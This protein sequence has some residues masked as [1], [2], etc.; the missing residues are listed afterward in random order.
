MEHLSLEIFDL[1]G[2][3]SKYAVLPEDTSITITD[4]SEI[5]ASGD[6]WSY[7]FTL[8]T[9]AN[10][11]IFGTAGEMHGA[12]LH[13]QVNRR[14]ARLWVEGLP[15]YYG[16]LR[17][18]DEVDVDKDG[19]V[20]VSF[21][22]GQKTFEDMIDGAKANQVP[23]IGNVRIGVALWRKRVVRCML[24]LK[25]AA[26]F[27]N[28]TRTVDA[29][30]TGLN[31]RVIEFDSD[32]EKSPAQ[33]YPRMVFPTG[34][35]KIFTG[36]TDEDADT[37][38]PDCINTDEPYTEDDDGTP[39]HPYCNVALCYQRYGY[40]RK[41]EDGS[42]RPDYST[43][44]EAQRGYEYMP[45]DRVNS[46]PNFFVIYWIRALMR[47]LGIDIE[48]NQMMD[49][50]DLRRLFFVN[51]DCAYKEPT[52]KFDYSNDMRWYRFGDGGRLVPERFDQKKNINKDESAFVGKIKNIGEPQYNHE[53]TLTEPIPTI[54][55]VV[56]GID[57]IDTSGETITKQVYENNNCYLHDAYA[58]SDC[59]P[60]ADIADVIKALESG[61]GVRFLFNDNYQRVR[62]VL[63]RNIFRS[64]EVQEIACD[65]ISDTK[66]ENS[67]RGFRMTYGNTEDTH[68]YYKG[69]ADLLPHKKPYFIDDSDD[70][71]YSHWNL[72]AEYANL[73]HRVSAFDKTCYVTP[74]TGNAYGI[75]V[76]KDA[77]RYDE[78]HP[79]LFEFAGF[80]DAEDGDC[81]GEENTIETVDVGFTPAIMND[82]NF[83]KE[84]SGEE[85]GQRF[86]L[87]VDEK[88]QPRRPD[89][90]TEEDYND[91]D[92]F[93]DVD[94]ILY[95]KK[96]GKNYDYQKMM[97][98]GIV[99][100]GEFAIMSDIYAEKEDLFANLV[101]EV[102]G[103]GGGNGEPGM[104]K[105]T[106]PVTFDVEGHI[107]EGY[108]LYLQDNY[109]PNDDGVSPVETHDWGLTLGI[110]RGSGDDAYVDYD[111]DPDD[112]EGNDTWDIVPGSTV[113]AH[114]DTCDCYGNEWDYNGSVHVMPGDATAKLFEMFPDSDA[115]FF[116][117]D[118]YITETMTFYVY[119][120]SGKRHLVLIAS[121]YD[122][123][124]T[125]VTGGAGDL[126]YFVQL[127]L[128]ELLAVSRGGRHM[129][130]EVDSSEER[131][132]TL[133]Q[134]C[135]IAFGG[136]NAEMILDDGVGSR[137]GRFSLKLRAEKLNPEYDPS[138]GDSSYNRR[139]L[140][141]TSESLR[142]RGLADQFYKEYSYWVRNARIAKRELRM[143]L[144][145]LLAIDKTKKVTIGDIT[146][147]IRKLQ[148]TVSNQTGLGIVTAE[149]MYI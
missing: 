124:G 122:V 61:F 28:N 65:V 71:D 140:P 126:R 120:T 110:M 77:K 63:L 68:F 103:I 92:A 6:V 116:G 111:Y 101:V 117:S 132:R 85:T 81:T 78:L 88:M 53:N 62:I 89:L 21:E 49:V 138:Q 141:I 64:K 118:G 4:T 32:D 96:D 36:N 83:E 75:K 82:L 55:R 67:I 148:Y 95:G 133:V 107:N 99:K 8:N 145:Q 41:M 57:E 2:T 30:V 7:S 38:S 20:D 19:N 134:L 129:V 137:Y 58:T 94:G 17:L 113:T 74:V 90:N 76:D 104:V 115:P 79:S 47:H 87:F 24:K 144:A 106:Y 136:I 100:P 84:R 80:M 66:T 11:H 73:I 109:E 69:F 121:A 37:F 14:R 127:T 91:P 48:E 43:S 18:D 25:A 131:G 102:L 22:S 93:Y 119:D 15:L 33:Q 147:F 45:A 46:A 59:F 135:R 56:V 86:A 60:D 105:V 108:R 139:Y 112:G 44:P 123:A 12:R 16:Y 130:V 128:E 13:E 72:D 26:V 9:A 5:F 70:H 10:A 98:D 51:T 97:S 35:F 40:E 149:I 23:T 50:E 125:T 27:T 52:R 31:G 143:E 142:G 42:I 1:T 146:G 34:E 54:D 29:I 3:G 39:T 114:P